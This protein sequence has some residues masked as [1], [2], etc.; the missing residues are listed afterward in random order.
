M[1]NGEK[2][3]A[4]YKQFGL[5]G[6]FKRTAKFFLRKIGINTN[7]YY[8]MINQI[9]VEA[10]RKQFEAANLTQVT[11]LTYDDFLIGDKSVFNEKKLTVIQQWLSEGTYKAYGIVE[12]GILIYSCWISLHKLETSDE[13]VVGCLDENE[14][15]LL[16]AYCSPAARG[17]GL[18]GAMN[19]YRLWQL[20]QNGKNQA[21]V[22]ILKE[23]KPAYK[24]QL[25]VGFEVLFT[26]SVVTIWGKTFTNYFRRKQKYR[27]NVGK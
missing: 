1:I 17:R 6:L 26:Y 12:N 10:R 9:D 22:I 15:L 2:F 8:Y 7:S 16:G 23:N 14:G 20:T 21:V 18:H 11:E 4:D 27:D 13:C 5:L 19:A 24:S 25:K 3:R